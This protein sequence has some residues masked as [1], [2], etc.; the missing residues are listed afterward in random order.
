MGGEKE[1]KNGRKREDRE[2][3]TKKTDTSWK[4]LEEQK[5]EKDIGMKENERAFS[6]VRRSA[7][8]F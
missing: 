6:A 1:R 4:M 8:N 2:E 5:E 7:G 3:K